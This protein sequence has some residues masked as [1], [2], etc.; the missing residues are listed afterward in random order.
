MLPY[1]TGILR[2]LPASGA[3]IRPCIA[4]LPSNC[5][6]KRASQ[7]SNHRLEPEAV[8]EADEIQM[9]LKMLKG[10]DDATAQYRQKLEAQLKELRPAEPST[11][12]GNNPLKALMKWL[13]VEDDKAATFAARRV[14]FSAVCT[15]VGTLLF[16][17]TFL[18]LMLAMQSKIRI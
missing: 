4:I 16:V 8:L 2:W 1:Q 7:K 14:L 9:I 18:F 12:R 5:R 17:L 11:T 15:F 6:E 3:S 13:G 10:N